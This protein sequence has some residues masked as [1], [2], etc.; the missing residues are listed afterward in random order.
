MQVPIIF[1]KV[2][3]SR[4]FDAYHISNTVNTYIRC[5]FFLA[6]LAGKNKQKSPKSQ[7]AK[8]SFKFSFQK[9]YMDV[10]P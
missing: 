6:L 2:L 10:N 9:R 5:V 4:L 7:T 3:F 8:Y 1:L